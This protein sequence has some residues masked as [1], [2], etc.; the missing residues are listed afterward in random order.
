VLTAT[1]A[2]SATF[3]AAAVPTYAD[4]SGGDSG[5]DV[6]AVELEELTDG[7]ETTLHS[8]ATPT[9]TGVSGADENTDVTGA[10][11]E[12]LSDGSETTLHSHATPTY[13]D[14]SGA[15]GDTDVTGAELEEL[16]DGSE[17]TLHSHA[18]FTYH[19][20]AVADRV[21][22]KETGTITSQEDNKLHDTAA[23]FETNNVEIN[24]YVHNETNNTWAKITAVDSE[25]ELT[26]DTNIFPD[27]DGDSYRVHGTK[28]S[29]AAWQDWTE[30]IP[31][32]ASAAVFSIHWEDND[33]GATFAIQSDVVAPS[34]TKVQKGRIKISNI[35]Q[36]YNFVCP[37]NS[38]TRQIYVVPSLWDNATKF[39][40]ACLGWWS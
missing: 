7:S 5:T 18:I 40:I 6:T 35:P 34:T 28:H 15:D 29:G 19:Y 24:D 17:T 10:E 1:G 36:Y 37:L 38:T 22:N 26:L 4:I 23:T 16:T 14:I 30:V 31:S 33:T 32:G 21:Q 20:K 13:T 11:L 8:H 2:G 25:T 39:D 27:N 12:E 9:Y 3:Q